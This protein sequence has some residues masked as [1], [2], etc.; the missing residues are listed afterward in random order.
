MSRRRLSGSTDQSGIVVR[1]WEVRE[2][3]RAEGE[4][5]GRGRSACVHVSRGV[6]TGNTMVD[7]VTEREWTNGVFCLEIKE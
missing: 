5:L 6:C 3:R 2:D 4:R 7:Y 1:S